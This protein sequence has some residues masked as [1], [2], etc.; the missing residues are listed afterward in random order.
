MIAIFQN[1]QSS[2]LDKFAEI[3]RQVIQQ[4]NKFQREQVFNLKISVGST[5]HKA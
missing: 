3:A 4:K 2:S 5:N 1:L